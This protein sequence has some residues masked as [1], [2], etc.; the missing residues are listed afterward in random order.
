MNP[1][2]VAKSAKNVLSSLEVNFNRLLGREFVPTQP[3]MLHIETCSA[4]NLKCLFCAYEKKQSAK[5]AMK[6][7]LFTDLIVQAVDMGYR[8]FEL[9]PCT[10]D[11]F[12]DHHAFNKFQIL[13]DNPQVTSYQFFT[14]FTIPK[15]KD[16]E[17]LIELKK[18][19]QM[20]ISIYGHD[21]ETFLAITKSTENLYRRLIA[22]LES[23]F[24]LLDRKKFLLDFGF[25]STRDV[26]HQP[27]SEM[28][29]L[30]ERFK[31][32][33][34]KVRTSNVYSNWGGFISQ[35]DVKGLAIDITGSDKTYKKGACTLLFTSVQ[36]MATGI[37][38]G[39]GVKDVEAS[40]R[41]GDLN[42]KP[43]HE[44]ISTRNP[45]YMKLIEDQQNGKFHP[46]C[47][48]C[49]YYKSVYHARSIYRKGLMQAQSIN[50]FKAQLD[51]KQPAQV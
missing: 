46:V 25:R 45:V 33:G 38:N 23:L 43:L 36:V 49:D 19:S 20:T 30:L 16:V 29:K 50:E 1:A 27:T 21:L 42:E 32:A 41:I 34:I 8:R 35:D 7:E 4:C 6:D 11:V 9:T 3:D 15:A 37:V 18:L 17:R 40:L 2:V 10:G 26:P 44:I 5:I 48:N 51:A 12:M 14:N 22:N 28:M 24:R 39:C 31:A 47:Q 13:E